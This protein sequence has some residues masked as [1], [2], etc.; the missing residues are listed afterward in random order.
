[1]SED[2]AGSNAAAI[3]QIFTVPCNE[4]HSGVMHLRYITYLTRLDQ[5][6]VT[7]PNFPAWICDVCG[8][9]DYDPRAISWLNTLLNPHAGRRPRAQRKP[10]PAPPSR[11]ASHE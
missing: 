7:V 1:M 9:R 3:H 6:L 8:R 2:S 11:P 4:C 10:R 5:S